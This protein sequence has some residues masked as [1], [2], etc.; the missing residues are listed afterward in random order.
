MRW[1]TTAA[2][3]V[4]LV[5]LGVFYYLYD[6]RWAPDR[7]Q[8][9]SRKGRVF[10]ADAKDVTEL[11]IKRGD[12]V[13]RAVREGE[14]WQ[15]TAPVK[16]RGNRGALDEAVTSILTAKIDREIAASPGALNEFGLDKP[17]ADVTLKLKDGKTLGLALGAKTP[18]GVWVYARERDK[19][20]VFVVSDSV[21]R[22]TTR[23]VADFRDRTI[24]AFDRK[25]VTGFEVAV[26][27]TRLV[28]DQ[29]GA[30]WNLTQPV[31]LPADTEFVN[32]MFE[33]LGAAKIKEFV[34]EAP[35]SRAPFGLERPL[36]L[37]IHTGRDKDRAD[38]SLLIGRLDP[39]RKGVYAMRPG[40][41][42]VVLLPEDV[43]KAV[44]RNVAVLRNKAIVELD[45]DKVTRLDLE[46]PKGTVSVA[47]ENDRWKIVAPQ[48]LPAD[49]VEVGAV[50]M[51]MR[52]LRA[53]A[54]LSDDGSG[55]PR[56]LPKPEV[57]ATLTQ[58]G[59]PPV[60]LLLAPSPDRRGGVPSAYAA[61]AGTGP[62]V[63]VEGNA[64]G[65]IGRSLDQL[66]D[67]TVLSGLEPKD[68]KRL[69][70]R[71]GGQTAVLER[72]GDEDWKMLEPT[73]SGAKS[74]KVTDVLYTLRALKWKDIVAPGGEEA[75][76]YGLD[77][78]SLEI[79]LFRAD[80]SEIATLLV[81][82]REGERAYVKTKAAPAIYAVDSRAL[83]EPPKV[84]DDF[85]G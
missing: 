52:A 28:V 13:V 10:T 33:K 9:A 37:T 63:L 38:R 65:E 66:R 7:E 8:A 29:A 5:A 77:A 56:Y 76:R 3:A 57:R 53:Q 64:L 82:K 23:P 50:L 60:T 84:P 80:G 26:D 32:E 31:A 69:R 68:I 61:L 24:L 46:T 17:A 49:P 73:K 79:A 21:L 44:P 41:P 39:E 18:T 71:A 6:V 58:Q 45:R 34:A 83:G 1:P 14:G 78:P 12:E 47:R 22:D 42:S 70:V 30:R 11:E 27:D 85:K 2:L 55:I 81:G 35:P 25:D 43:F 40:E 54:F 59:A 15:L 75:A 62:V 48:A 74:A 19:P 4:L 36:R 16:W 72:A 20:A 51:K 67:H